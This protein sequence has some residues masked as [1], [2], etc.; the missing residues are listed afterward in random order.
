MKQTAKASKKARQKKATG[1]SSEA[2]ITT[3]QMDESKEDTIEAPKQISSEMKTLFQSYDV[4]PDDFVEQT[5]RI[6]GRTT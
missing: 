4:P 6:R 3:S 2:T 5:K 1:Q